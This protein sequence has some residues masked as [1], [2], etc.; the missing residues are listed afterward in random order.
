LFR[1]ALLF[2]TDFILHSY[3]GTTARGTMTVS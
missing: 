1:I 2:Y 3:K